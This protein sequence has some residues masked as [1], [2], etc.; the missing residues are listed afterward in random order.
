MLPDSKLEWELWRIKYEDGDM[1]GLD[2]I[3]TTAST[4]RSHE[5]ESG[6]KPGPSTTTKKHTDVNQHHHIRRS[7]KERIRAEKENEEYN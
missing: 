4:K 1:E 5:R 3:E 7:E 2:I 6:K